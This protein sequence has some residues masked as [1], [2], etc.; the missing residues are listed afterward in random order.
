M[1]SSSSHV[2]LYP[3]PHTQNSKNHDKSFQFAKLTPPHLSKFHLFSLSA[4]FLI[5]Q[6]SA[7]MPVAA[8]G[9]VSGGIGFLSQLFTSDSP[10]STHQ[11]CCFSVNSSPLHMNFA[12]SSCLV[13]RGSLLSTRVSVS[14]TGNA[15]I[16]GIDGQLSLSSDE[17][18]PTRV[19]L[20]IH[21]C[22]VE[23]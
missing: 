13:K 11:F 9:S 21:I 8:M 12:R 6:T 5:L 16:D 7:T 23:T 19:R 18:K 17:I 22:K 4:Q 15:K 14:T 10:A 2:S 1:C 3:N 20:F